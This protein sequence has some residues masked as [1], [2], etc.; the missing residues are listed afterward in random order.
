MPKQKK[1]V[2]M[3]R[4]RRLR[5]ARPRRRSYFRIPSR[6]R[7]RKGIRFNWKNS[8]IGAAG[9]MAVKMVR[10]HLVNLGNYNTP[11]ESIATGAVLKMVGMDNTDLI[12]AGI[13]QGIAQVGRDLL[14]GTL[15]GG[16]T[17]NEGG[18]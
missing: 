14:S 7:V 8:L 6:R 16:N 2:R 11:V 10:P 13:K 15:F 18:V 1:V 9:L 3:P 5:Y 12:S 17:N 4:R